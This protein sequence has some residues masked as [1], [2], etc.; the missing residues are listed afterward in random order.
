MSKLKFGWSEVSLVPE[1]KKI[2]L[3]GQFYERITDTVRD[4]IG[5]TAL[6][7][8][9]DDIAIFCACDL[10]S[11][12]SALIKS[13][14]DILKKIEGFPYD[15]VIVNAIHSHT[16]IS[17]A[18][19]NDSYGSTLNVLSQYAP[20]NVEYDEF[21]SD[22]SGDLLDGEEAHAFIAEK[23]A[24]AAR[25]AYANLKEGK[26][27]AGFGR[28]AVGMCRRVCY[29]DGSAKMWGDTNF[30]NFTE[31]EG[32]NDSGI[33]MLFITD[34]NEKLTGVV[35]NLACPSQILEHRSVISADFWG[36]VKKNLRKKFGE[37]VCLLPLCSPAGDQCPRDMI[38]WVEPESPINDPNIIRENV[39]ARNADPSM[40]DEAGCVRAARRIS[41]EIFYAY[42]DITGYISDTEFEHKI[43]ELDMPLRRVT[44]EEKDRALGAI[45][46]FF[47]N[48]KGAITFKDNAAMH[49][50]AGTVTRYEV[51]QT[52]ET[53]PIEIHILRLGDVA[54]ATNPYELFLNYGNQIR[55]RS[56]AKQTFLIQLCC[57][58][59]GYLP[60]EKA[61]KGGHYSAYVSSGC[62]GHE[63]G[64]L[65]VRKTL[66]EINKMF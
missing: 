56:K 39:P 55:A 57:G 18:R 58:S 33:E 21:A 19:S 50:H 13:A 52:V 34:E 46:D 11:A 5:V 31:L 26:F 65:L 62:T 54:F 15:K 43:I 29:D 49:V 23:I 12:S 51:Q 28:A 9:S 1:G 41:D 45:R 36:D 20:E 42:E 35:A 53:D 61:E 38:R 10:E 63:G 66:G 64:D 7:I 59:K 3:A 16:S 25:L 60:T 32:G 37:N 48:H 14:R 2:N 30:A 22:T 17:Y 4:Q 40:F 44:I 27:A 47:A 8:E 6:A 24:E